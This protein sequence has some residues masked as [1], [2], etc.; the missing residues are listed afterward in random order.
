MLLFFG[1]AWSSFGLLGIFPGGGAGRLR[2][3]ESMSLYIV[4]AGP[5]RGK[6]GKGSCIMARGIVSVDGAGSGSI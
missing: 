1:T 4:D 3:R 2:K 6:L 5:E